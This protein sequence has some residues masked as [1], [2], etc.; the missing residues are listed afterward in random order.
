MSEIP[1]ALCSIYDAALEPGQWQVALKRLASLFR[2]PFADKF[3][4]NHDRSFYQGIAIG[5]DATD[6]HG[7][8]LG[9]WS[10]RNVWRARRPVTQAGEIVTS[11]DILPKE[12]LIRSE[13]YNDYLRP[14]ELHEGLRL[15]I[16]SGPTGIEDISLLRPWSM[17]SYTP[18]ERELAGFLMP[19]L[20]R[21]AAISRRLAPEAPTLA[22]SAALDA[23]QQATMVLDAAGRVVHATEPALRLLQEQD[24]LAASGSQ[25]RAMTPSVTAQL[26]KAL[27]LATR[28]DAAR[29]SATLHL[30]SRSGGRAITLTLIPLNRGE[31]WGGAS[32][33][34]LAHLSG[35]PDQPCT[36]RERMMTCYKLTSA[37][38]AVVE[39]LAAG[40]SLAALARR[41]HRSLNTVRTHLARVMSK[42]GTSRQSEIVRLALA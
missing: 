31:G 14:R 27:Q 35:G 17:G 41:T 2:A 23:A 6:Y 20:R 32:G 3:S 34:V 8:F 12:E 5:L 42:T 40:E 18:E 9:V 30:P 1:Q 10:K 22:G 21:S 33:A 11:R 29:L 7:Q 26:C 15:A 16:W 24:V 39:A 19:H 13:M 36:I 4:R 28:R 25:L 38:A 37:E